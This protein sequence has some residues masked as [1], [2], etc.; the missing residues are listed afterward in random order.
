MTWTLVALA[1]AVPQAW[2]NGG[3]QTRELLA[4]PAATGWRVRMSVADV[5]AAGPFSRFDGRERWFAVLDGAGVDLQVGA[6]Q[7]RLTTASAAFRFDGAAGV[8]CTPVEGSTR[9]FNL[10]AAP[11]RAHLRRARGALGV[12][13]AAGSLVAAYAHSRGAR[14]SLDD[15]D[16]EV[17]AFHLA[18]RLQEGSGRGSIVGDDAL[19]ME[20]RP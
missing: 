11:G 6:E 17:P 12:T 15:G 10:M 13:P 19:W 4:W 18:W 9:D 7:H 2:R 14:I 5:S 20:A 1:D 8:A 3:G 16:L